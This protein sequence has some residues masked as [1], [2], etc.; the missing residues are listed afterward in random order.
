MHSWWDTRSDEDKR[1]DCDLYYTWGDGRGD[2]DAYIDMIGDGRDM[3]G[4]VARDSLDEFGMT[5]GQHYDWVAARC[6]QDGYWHPDGLVEPLPADHHLAE[7]A[8]SEDSGLEFA[9]PDAANV[10]ASLD[11][12]RPEDIMLST[13]VPQPVLGVDPSA[14]TMDQS[15]RSADSAINAGYRYPLPPRQGE[16]ASQIAAFVEIYRFGSSSQAEEALAAMHT[17]AAACAGQTVREWVCE[18]C[19]GVWTFTLEGAEPLSISSAQASVSYLVLNATDL[20]S[21]ASS[22]VVGFAQGDYVALV[23]VQRLVEMSSDST[24]SGP[25]SDVRVPGVDGVQRLAEEVAA[26]LVDG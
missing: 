2:R 3:V 18:N 5:P 4:E 23:T 26:N 10:A 1:V 25:P 16:G 12:D 21:T 20:R 14:C 8:N 11:L 19:D 6:S 24:S 22:R 13:Q 17:T 7:E 9:L 15:L